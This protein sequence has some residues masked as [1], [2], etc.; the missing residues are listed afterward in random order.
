MKRHMERVSTGLAD[1]GGLAAK[2]EA[3]ERNILKSAEKR[4]VSVAAEIERAQP[5]IEAS[6]DATQ[7]RYLKLVEER[8]QLELV[9][10]KARKVLGE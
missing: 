6:S 9:I 2:T 4:M 3:S 1:L 7:D 10:S 5:G 8:S